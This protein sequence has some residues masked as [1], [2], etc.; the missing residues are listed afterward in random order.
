MAVLLVAVASVPGM[1]EPRR[2]G[3]WGAVVTI[4]Y[5]VMEG[6]EL[7]GWRKGRIP[8]AWGGGH[9]ERPGPSRGTCLGYEGSIKPCPAH[10]TVGL[11]CSGLVRWIYHLAYGRDV[12][13]NGTTD[14]QLRKLRRIH[15]EAARPGDLVYYGK[16]SRKKVKTTHVG[17]YVGNGKMI[18]ALR[19]GTWVRLDRLDA[20]DGFAGFFRLKSI[21]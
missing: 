15:A 2:E 6:R 11:D 4:A 21:H 18:N 9:A 8:Y 20:V 5:A 10:R 13:G 3:K 19:T 16:V 17:V 14:D 12:L 1:V 7:P